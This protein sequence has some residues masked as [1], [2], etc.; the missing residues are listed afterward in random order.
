MV[1]LSLNGIVNAMKVKPPVYN[2]RVTVIVCV[3][4]LSLCG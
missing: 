3:C 2:F 1:C 4:V